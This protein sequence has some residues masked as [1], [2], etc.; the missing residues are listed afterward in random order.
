MNKFK[1]GDRIKI[2]RKPTTWA[3]QLSSNNP[4]NNCQYKLLLKYKMR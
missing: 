4:M 1:V 3:S 2:Y